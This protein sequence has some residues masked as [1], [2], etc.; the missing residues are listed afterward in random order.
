MDWNAL[1][2]VSMYIKGRY[3]WGIAATKQQIKT[4]PKTVVL[5]ATVFPTFRS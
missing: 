1:W 3:W 2:A 5:F 4:T